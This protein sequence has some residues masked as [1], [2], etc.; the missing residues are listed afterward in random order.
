MRNYMLLF[1]VFFIVMSVGCGSSELTA[2]SGSDVT[3]YLDQH[4]EMRAETDEAP[5]TTPFP[6]P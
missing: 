6:T 1:P 4:P 2:P 3:S 5:P